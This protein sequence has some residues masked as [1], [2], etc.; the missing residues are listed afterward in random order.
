MGCNEGQH[1]GRVWYTVPRFTLRKPPGNQK[2]HPQF[3][4]S[5]ATALSF[6]M[7]SLELCCRGEAAVGNWGIYYRFRALA[8][9]HY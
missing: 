7:V 3:N 9:A 5:I 2:L 6:L 8:Y 4:V 1:C